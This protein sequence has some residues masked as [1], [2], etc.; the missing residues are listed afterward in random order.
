MIRKFASAYQSAIKGSASDIETTEL[1]GGAKICQIFQETFC[2]E[3]DAI[4]S[5]DGQTNDEIM[6]AIK[7]ASG[8]AP[9]LNLQQPVFEMLVK[10]QLKKLEEP[11]LR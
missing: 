2:K 1:F 11:S 10:K 7:N 9:A 8:L 6:C 5:L 4:D 3:L